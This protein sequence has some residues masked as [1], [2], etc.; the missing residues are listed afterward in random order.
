MSL[1]PIEKA[2]AVMPLFDRLRPQYREAARDGRLK[3][4]A[5][6]DGS[7]AWAYVSHGLATV[8]PDEEAYG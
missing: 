3:A 8:I 7:I 6:D 5:R 4:I 1:D 2:R